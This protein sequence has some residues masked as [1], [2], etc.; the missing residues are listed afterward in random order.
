MESGADGGAVS[1]PHGIEELMHRRQD[2]L[3]LRIGSLSRKLR[4]DHQQEQ[5]QSEQ[6]HAEFSSVMPVTT[7]AGGF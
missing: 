6:A 1:L 7:T 5:E 3:T 2:R 4:G